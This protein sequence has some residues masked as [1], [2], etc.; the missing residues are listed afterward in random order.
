M[1][2]PACGGSCNPTSCK[3]C[4]PCTWPMVCCTSGSVGTCQMPPCP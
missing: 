3:K 4:G 1:N 2:G